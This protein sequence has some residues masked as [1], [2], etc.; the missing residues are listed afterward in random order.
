M[1][2]DDRKPDAWMPVVIGA[3]LGDTTHLS[4]EQHGAY[5]LLLL[6]GWKRGG[7]L[8]NDEAQLASIA[9]LTPA[10]W[11]QHRGVLLAFWMVDGGLLVQKRQVEE[12]ARAVAFNERQQANGSKGGRPKKNPDQTQTKPTGYAWDNPD[13]NPDET[14]TPSPLPEASSTGEINLTPPAATVGEGDREGVFEGNDPSYEPPSAPMARALTA[15][16]FTCTWRNAALGE[17]A[18]EGGDITHLRQIA[19]NPGAVGKTAG[20]LIAWARRELAEK[21][22]PVAPPRNTAP[23]RQ[24]AG[25]ASILGVNPHDRPTDHRADLVHAGDQDGPREPVR[26]LPGRHAG[27]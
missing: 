6:A 27:G 15:L 17:Y 7:N 21:A 9:K 22:Q 8:P 3:Y 25:V 23:S 19:A 4:T 14:P 16:G 24:L 12:Y 26:A 5:F 1:K 18:A 2:N 20:Y 10:K 11:R 13:H